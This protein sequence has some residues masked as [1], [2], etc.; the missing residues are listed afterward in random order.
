MNTVIPTV[1]RS[2]LLAELNE[3]RFI[4]Q[5]NNGS[6]QIFIVNA[7]NSPNTIREI[8]RLR[9]ITFR[10]AGGGTGKEVDVDKYDLAEV[11]YEQLIVWNP[12]DAEIVGGYRFICCGKALPDERGE[13]MLATSVHFS[14][15]E[16][17]KKD[18]L[19]YTIELGRSFVQ[20]KYQPGND[21]RKGLFS[22]DNIWDGLGA[23]VVDYPEIRYFFGKVTMYLHF[24]QKARDLILFF[25]S[26]YFPDPD[27]L[28]RPHEPLSLHGNPP[29]YESFFKDLDYKEAFKVL[30]TEVR[31]LGENIPPLVNIYMNLTPTM[32][33]FGT[34]LNHTFGEVEETGIMVTIADIHESKKERH[35]K[36]YTGAKKHS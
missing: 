24:N 13:P 35:I 6:N 1:E 3:D 25:L 34:M 30:N 31:S 15:S 2:L 11:P 4:R 29:E 36:S 16:R 19:P 20:P 10:Q 28:V 7:H 5:T 12:K 23:I 8:G 22:L 33:T 17:F 26:K 14:F 32:K 9:E 27:A 18:Y 21:P